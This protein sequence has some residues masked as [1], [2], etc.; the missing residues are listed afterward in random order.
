MGTVLVLGSEQSYDSCLITGSSP[1]PL[2]EPHLITGFLYRTRNRGD[3]V[4]AE[5]GETPHVRRVERCSHEI[6]LASWGGGEAMVH[7]QCQ[8]ASHHVVAVRLSFHCDVSGDTLRGKFERKRN[9]CSIMTC[10]G[11][12]SINVLSNLIESHAMFGFSARNSESVVD[13]EPCS[14]RTLF[15]PGEYLACHK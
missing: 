1:E 15:P 10:S 5:T 8:T 14:T 13:Q 3:L 9:F 7:N 6:L 4:P 12:M 2:Q 11:S